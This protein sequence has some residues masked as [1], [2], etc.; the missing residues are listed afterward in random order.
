[1]PDTP[2]SGLMVDWFLIG[3]LVSHLQVLGWLPML[4]GAV[5]GHLGLL[6]L[7][8]LLYV[9]LKVLWVL[10]LLIFSRLGCPS[11]C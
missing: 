10:I 5:V 2:M 8:M 3:L 11:E 4:S 9:C 6:V 7:K 1:M